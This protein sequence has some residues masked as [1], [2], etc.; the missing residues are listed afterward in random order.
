[1]LVYIYMGYN[2]W[3]IPILNNQPEIGRGSQPGEHLSERRGRRGIAGRQRVAIR[4]SPASFR[5]SSAVTNREV[6]WVCLKMLG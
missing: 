3:Y 5:G 1:M 6:I 4:E 2:L